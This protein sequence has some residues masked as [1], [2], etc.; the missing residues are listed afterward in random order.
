LVPEKP[1]AQTQLPFGW[2][3]PWPEQVVASENWQPV[4]VWPAEQ[5]QVPDDEQD[6]APLQVV[7]AWQKVQVG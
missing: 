4:P 3:V 2:A 1:A 6:P 5:T 7:A